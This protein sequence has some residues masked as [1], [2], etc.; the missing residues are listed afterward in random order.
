MSFILR[1]P[2]CGPRD[3]SEFRYGGQI[4][5]APAGTLECPAS[6]LPGPQW[7][8][9]FHRLGCQRWFAAQRNVLTNEIVITKEDLTA[10]DQ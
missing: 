7:E 8:R 10:H 4:L 2:H 3:V 6:N 5:P 9:W 1:C